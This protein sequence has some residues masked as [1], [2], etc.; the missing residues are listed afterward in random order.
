MSIAFIRSLFADLRRAAE[1]ASR[2]TARK[3]SNAMA[4]DHLAALPDYLREDI[5]LSENADI[6]ELVEHGRTR[7]VARDDD[8]RS[9]TILPHAL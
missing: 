6:A 5:G 3:R 4:V 8:R 2:E 7:P 1:I 9:L